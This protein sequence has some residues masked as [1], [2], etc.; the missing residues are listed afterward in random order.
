MRLSELLAEARTVGRVP[1]LDVTSL[2]YDS[3]RVGPGAAFFAFPGEHVDGHDFIPAA[4]ERGAVAVISERAAPEIDGIAW[5][6][7]EHGRRALARAALAFYRRPDRKL[8]LIAVTGTNGKD[9][10]RLL[11]RLDSPGRRLSDS[12]PRYDRAPGGGALHA[13]GGIRH[14]NH[15][16]WFATSPSSWTRVVRTLALRLRPMRWRS[17]GSTAARSTPRSL[18]T[19]RRIIWTCT[20]TWRPMSGLREGCSRARA[21]RRRSMR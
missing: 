9:D 14:R 11:D 18:R 21:L 3:R 7:V 13:G 17:A 10:Q 4:Q 15:L 20:A 2:E 8:H 6:Q 1:E 12:P 5:A 16:T 19:S